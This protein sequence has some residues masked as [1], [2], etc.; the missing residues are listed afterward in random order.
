MLKALAAITRPRLAGV[1]LAR[2]FGL[3]T[4]AWE[5]EVR[6]EVV[7]GGLVRSALLRS[8]WLGSSLVRSYGESLSYRKF[9]FIAK[10][11]EEG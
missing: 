5:P 4:A 6:P 11:Q 10:H 9:F 2:G 7:G 3:E 1:Q 8:T